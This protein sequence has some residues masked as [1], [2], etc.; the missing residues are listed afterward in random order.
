MVRCTCVVVRHVYMI[1]VSGLTDLTS[2]YT[3]PN[4]RPQTV[5]S[6]SDVQV[7]SRAVVRAIGWQAKRLLL[8]V[9]LLYYII[10]ITYYIVYN[11][12][13]NN[14]ACIIYLLQEIQVTL[15]SFYDLVVYITTRLLYNMHR[16]DCLSLLTLSKCIMPNQFKNIC[17]EL[18]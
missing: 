2:V 15:Y 17:V 11:Y 5:E 14:N 3:L 4:T 16:L 10:H 6:R 8:F 7:N 1:Y 13:I 12:I 9:L 18:K